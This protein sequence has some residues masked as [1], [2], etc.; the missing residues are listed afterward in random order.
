MSTA[1]RHGTTPASD[2]RTWMPYGLC[3]QT[4]LSL[5]FPEGRG[6]AIA[7]Q[8]EQAKKVC[9]RCP[10][11]SRCLEYAVDTGQNF[12][13]WGGLDEGERLVLVRQ[14]AEQRASG[15]AVC[16]EHQEFVERRAAEGASHREIA[17]ELG[18]NHTSV[19]RALRFFR[20]ERKQAEMAQQEV[21]AV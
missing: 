1:T 3:R 10:V 19:G 18:V 8:I 11:R 4:D 13:V 20:N 15:Y 12:G 14:R 2:T 9:D 6:A 21:A 7:I 5:F 17:D 16:I